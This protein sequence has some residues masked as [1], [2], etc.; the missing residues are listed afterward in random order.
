P[1]DEPF[2]KG[3]LI[4]E[5]LLTRDSNDH[6]RVFAEVQGYKHASNIHKIVYSLKQDQHVES[7]TEEIDVRSCVIFNCNYSSTY[8]VVAEL[9]FTDREN[10]T[11]E[12]NSVDLSVGLQKIEFDPAKSEK[13]PSIEPKSVIE[14]VDTN[15]EHALFVKFKPNGKEALEKR[16][17]YRCN[18]RSVF[19]DADKRR[20][21]SHPMKDNNVLNIFK[22]I[23]HEDA[24]NEQ[25]LALALELDALDEVEYVSLET[26]EISPPIYQEL[27]EM[28]KKAVVEKAEQTPEFTSRQTY[29][30]HPP[31]MN[32]KYAWQ[33]GITGK[34]SVVRHLDFGLIENHEDLK[35]LDIVSADGSSP[36]HGT[37]SLG[38]IRSTHNEFGTTGIAYGGTT[39][40][41]NINQLSKIV[42]DSNPGD[43]VS[44]D[45]QFS[46]CTTY[47]PFDFSRS[48]WDLI[49]SATQSGVIVILAAGNGGNYL[50]TSSCGSLAYRGDNGGMLVGAGSSSS[51]ERLGFSNYGTQVMIN[52]WGENVTTTGYGNLYGERGGQ[53]SYTNTFNGT[54]SATPLCA[55]ALALIQSYSKTV[56]HVTLDGAFMRALL[57]WTG[58]SSPGQKIGVRP[59]IKRAMMKLDEIFG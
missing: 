9:Y 1:T 19:S 47:Y 3:L 51:F 18:F 20:I 25:L 7:A 5:V 40:V 55:G 44:L 29:M 24:S 36:D 38:C 15:Q 10:I 28:G 39:Y 14:I 52:S 49:K 57:K 13:L 46:G 8:S 50:D 35:E 21:E 48:N 31:G 45:I 30:N 23:M 37:A 17:K 41:Y 58:N 33:Q 2:L 22:V 34:A 54:S 16:G 43:I 32:V 53:Q 59:D 11:I 26:T 42:A 4:M 12:S 27:M 6:Q 56:H